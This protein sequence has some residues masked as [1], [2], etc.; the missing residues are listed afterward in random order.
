MR[1]CLTSERS[2]SNTFEMGEDLAVEDRAWQQRHEE[3][4][5]GVRPVAGRAISR[6][7]GVQRLADVSVRTRCK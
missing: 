4:L 6:T 7:D 2:L 1:F 5:D 3:M